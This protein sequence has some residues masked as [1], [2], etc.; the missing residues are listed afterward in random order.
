MRISFGGL[1]KAE[2]YKY[3]K[4]ITYLATFL[5]MIVYSIVFAVIFPMLDNDVE[6]GTCILNI[7]SNSIFMNMLISMLIVPFVINDFQHK[8]IQHTLTLGAN[9][10][11]II[12]AKLLLVSATCACA[13]ALAIILGSVSAAALSS[14]GFVEISGSFVMQAAIAELVFIVVF[15]MFCMLFYIIVRSSAAY[16][17]TIFALWLSMFGSMAGAEFENPIVNFLVKYNMFG[18]NQL[19]ICQRMGTQMYYYT[20]MDW[21][22]YLLVMG[23]TGGVLYVL[24]R[25]VFNK[26]EVR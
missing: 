24:I 25:V 11:M 19:M 22:E 21:I 1:M 16:V 14:K 6:V 5:A 26:I 13:Y 17:M 12:N 23:I 10:S 18:Q 4:S 9:R 8:T 2:F 7:L 15:V 3:R 20:A